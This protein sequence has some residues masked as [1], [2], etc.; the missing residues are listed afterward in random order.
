MTYHNEKRQGSGDR[1]AQDLELGQTLF[2][3]M[4]ESADP[5]AM[6]FCCPSEADRDTIIDGH[7]DLTQIAVAFLLTVGTSR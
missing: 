6:V 5:H 2:R 1:P 3:I 4:R 7:F